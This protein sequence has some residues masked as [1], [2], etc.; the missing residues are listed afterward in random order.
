MAF[1]SLCVRVIVLE[2][3]LVMTSGY[4]PPPRTMLQNLSHLIGF[5]CVRMRGDKTHKSHKTTEEASS[6][7]LPEKWSRHH[8][9]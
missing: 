2:W 4:L 7:A 9:V 3:S 1:V 5:W 8:E 6:S